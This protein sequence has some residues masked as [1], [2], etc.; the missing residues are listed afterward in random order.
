MSHE[1]LPKK[2]DFLLAQVFF[3][4]KRKSVPISKRR[5]ANA[6]T[7][8]HLLPIHQAEYVLPACLS[9]LVGSLQAQR[10]NN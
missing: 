5:A 8:S 10:T 7:I 1:N 6:R 4:E 2:Q 9:G 3:L